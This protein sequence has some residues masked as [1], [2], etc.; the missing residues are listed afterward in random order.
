[1]KELRAPQYKNQLLDSMCHPSNKN[2]LISSDKKKKKRTKDWLV[3]NMKNFLFSPQKC[4]AG[5]ILQPE[6]KPK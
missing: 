1:M 3:T 6:P 5:V 2:N 4:F